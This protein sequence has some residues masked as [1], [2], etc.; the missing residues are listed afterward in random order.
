MF[1]SD[2]MNA[3]FKQKLIVSLALYVLTILARSH[4]FALDN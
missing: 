4:L 2:Q 1:F 3:L